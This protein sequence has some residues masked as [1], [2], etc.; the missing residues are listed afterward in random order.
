MKL[1][2]IVILLLVA[3]GMFFAGRGCGAKVRIETRTDTIVVCDT[4]R[5][6]L[7]V[8]IRSYIVR[9][10]TVWMQPV[11]D[12]IRIEVAVPIERKTYLT[13]DYRA[14]VEGF[15]PRLVE[16][17]LYRKTTFITTQTTLRPPPQRWGIGVQAGVGFT[18]KGLKPYIGVGIQY[19]IVAW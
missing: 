2:V 7:L 12:T 19:R 13:A 5:D 4:V 3:G 11:R 8:P 6:T 1:Q 9:V 14:V 17:E 18:P 10:D 15:R 16:M